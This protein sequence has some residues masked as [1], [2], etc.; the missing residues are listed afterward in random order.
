MH[1]FDLAY[2]CEVDLPGR[3]TV[4]GVGKRSQAGLSLLCN[5][6]SSTSGFCAIL[7]RDLVAQERSLSF[8]YGRPVELCSSLEQMYFGK[9]GASCVN[10]L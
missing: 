10:L 4:N 5:T 1:K 2:V 3:T 7:S 6:D 9:H 8:T